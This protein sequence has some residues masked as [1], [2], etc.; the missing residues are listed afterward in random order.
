LDS[1]IRDPNQ[2]RVTMLSP[3]SRTVGPML[4]RISC[5]VPGYIAAAVRRAKITYQTGNVYFVSLK[6]RCRIAR[7]I[8]RA[9]LVPEHPT[10]TQ[11]TKVSGKESSSTEITPFNMRNMY[12]P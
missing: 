2:S 6:R 11:I 4:S 9:M 12:V 8:M 3:M 5:S 1:L 10:V 7:M